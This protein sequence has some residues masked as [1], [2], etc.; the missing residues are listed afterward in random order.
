[1]AKSIL[2][3]RWWKLVSVLIIEF[4][5][6]ITYRFFQ[7]VC[8]YAPTLK[9]HPPCLSPINY[10]ILFFGAIIAIYLL[11]TIVYSAVNKKK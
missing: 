5:L 10:V 8:G 6:L 11:I 9:D 3:F 4:F 2:M 7:P 1:M